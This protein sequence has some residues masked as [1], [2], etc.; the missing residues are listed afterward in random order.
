[1]FITVVHGSQEKKTAV[2]TAWD[3]DGKFEWLNPNIE[4]WDGESGETVEFFVNIERNGTRWRD[5]MC[6]I[7]MGEYRKK[8]ERRFTLEKS[9][10]PVGKLLARK[11]ICSLFLFLACKMTSTH[12]HKYT[13]HIYI[14]PHL[15]I[16]LIQFLFF[17]AGV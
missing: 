8:P 6:T 12:E 7:T 13:I 10:F 3:N 15:L 17:Y 16:V 11:L 9:L 2:Q 4:L 5:S 14:F 1:M